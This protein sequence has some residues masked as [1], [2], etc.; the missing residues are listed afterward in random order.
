MSEIETLIRREFH[1]LSDGAN[2]DPNLAAKVIK[3]SR[4]R[5]FRQI[6]LLAIFTSSVSVI[7]ILGY[8]GVTH[9]LSPNVT[10]VSDL[11][12]TTQDPTTQVVIEPE[13]AP[14]KSAQNQRVVS[15]YPVSWEDSIGDLGAISKPAGIGNTLGGL[16]ATSLTISWSKCRV[17]KCPTSWTLSVVNTTEEFVLAEPSLMVYVDHAPLIS[18]SRPLSLLPGAKANLVFSFPEFADITNVGNKATW[19]WNWF[20]TAAR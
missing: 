9:L 4:R 7:S 20:L 8:V 16:K 3:A 17:G 11:T 19:Q 2:D 6:T 15:E 18:T 1:W 12:M 10:Q 13:K 5:K 14:T